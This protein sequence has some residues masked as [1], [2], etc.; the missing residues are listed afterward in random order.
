MI[1]TRPGPPPENH[2]ILDLNFKKLFATIWLEHVIF[3]YIFYLIIDF[4]LDRIYH[5]RFSLST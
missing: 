4:K 5:P 2:N 3:N 1:Y